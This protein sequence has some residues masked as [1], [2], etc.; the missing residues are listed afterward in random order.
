ML[1]GILR[2]SGHLFHIAVKLLHLSLVALHLFVVQQ[3]ASRGILRGTCNTETFYATQ[4]GHYTSMVSHGITIK[5]NM[6][7]KTSSYDM[8][9]PIIIITCIKHVFTAGMRRLRQMK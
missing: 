8:N 3:L 7:Y 9:M 4:N 2:Y 5:I 1:H 6:L